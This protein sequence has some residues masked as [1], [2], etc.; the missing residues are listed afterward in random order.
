MNTWETPDVMR[1]PASCAL[2]QAVFGEMPGA[3]CRVLA[4]TA[5][6][7]GDFDQLSIGIE[8]ISRRWI[9]GSASR[10]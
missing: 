9:T 2:D 5:Q 4:I 1:R 7:V 8:L 3:P 10:S 6:H